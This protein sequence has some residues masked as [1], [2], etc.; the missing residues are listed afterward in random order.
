METS[1][2]G[3]G[4]AGVIPDASALE[5]GGLEFMLWDGK[6]LEALK[7]GIP[8]VGLHCR[9]IALEAGREWTAAGRATITLGVR[10]PG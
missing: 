9:Q 10:C 8:T 1:A 3:R 2:P 6:L 4:G 5:D 7:Q